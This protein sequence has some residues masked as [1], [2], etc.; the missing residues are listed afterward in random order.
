MPKFKPFVSP[1]E[2]IY[3]FKLKPV[4]SKANCLALSSQPVS[5]HVSVLL[6]ITCECNISLTVS[7]QTPL[8]ALA[9]SH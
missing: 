7:Y 1:V 3:T 6:T 4:I 5:L 9:I 8:T 2:H